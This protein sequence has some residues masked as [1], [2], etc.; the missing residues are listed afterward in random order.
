MI[1]KSDTLSPLCTKAGIVHVGSG[2]I[3]ADRVLQ[4]KNW[5]HTKEVHSEV[6]EK[7]RGL[8][9]QMGQ[10]N[11]ILGVQVAPLTSLKQSMPCREGW[12][13]GYRSGLGLGLRLWDGLF[14]EVSS[15][16][17]WIRYGSVK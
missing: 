15:R 1:F 16:C 12:R 9:Q 10:N 13:E 4:E 17:V 5:I 3:L 7:L 11:R 6:E 2:D 8:L 14:S